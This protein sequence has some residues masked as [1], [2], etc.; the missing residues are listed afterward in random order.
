MKT[1][2]K[3]SKLSAESSITLDLKLELKGD[4]NDHS[5]QM[6]LREIQKRVVG[7]AVEDVEGK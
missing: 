3:L 6:A 4:V 2:M 1:A 7:L 5:V